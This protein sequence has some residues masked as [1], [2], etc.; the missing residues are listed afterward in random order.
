MKKQYRLL[1]SSFLQCCSLQIH[2]S[3]VL[4]WLSSELNYFLGAQGI[5][6]QPPALDFQEKAGKFT[7]LCSIKDLPNTGE[8]KEG[9]EDQAEDPWKNIYYIFLCCRELLQ[10]GWELGVSWQ[11]SIWA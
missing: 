1:C 6:A 9:K 5:K 10:L 2:Q 11:G 4:Q 3:L 8:N 7:N